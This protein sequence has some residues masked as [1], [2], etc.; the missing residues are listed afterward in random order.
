MPVTQVAQKSGSGNKTGIMNNLEWWDMY[1]DIYGYFTHIYLHRVLD[2]ATTLGYHGLTGYHLNSEKFARLAADAMPFEH[3]AP[4]SC[5]FL[6]LTP[7]KRHPTVKSKH[8]VPSCCFIF[9]KQYRTSESCKYK[10][11]PSFWEDLPTPWRQ[12][13]RI[14]ST[15]GDEAFT[16]SAESHAWTYLSSISIRTLDMEVPPHWFHNFQCE[17]TDSDQCSDDSRIKPPR[18]EFDLRFAQDDVAS[19][20]NLGYL[21]G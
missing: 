1:M 9:W 3:L 17:W 10:Q 6:A 12:H 21:A 13:A 2:V 11:V 4:A 18:L 19:Q 5:K 20:L 8:C 7:R 14:W 16:R 15:N